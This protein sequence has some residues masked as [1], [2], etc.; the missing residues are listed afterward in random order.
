MNTN[1]T[2]HIVIDNEYA[3][4]V[5]QRISQFDDACSIHLSYIEPPTNNPSDQI[6]TTEITT[7]TNDVTA[8]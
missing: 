6:T 5:L 4:T 8:L 7:S 3:A 2:G 1:K